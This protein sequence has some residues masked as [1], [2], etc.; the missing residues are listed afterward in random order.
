MKVK[1][2]L[3][4][5]VLACSTLAPAQE[6]NPNPNGIFTAGLSGNV[7][8]V[9]PNSPRLALPALGAQ[10]GV[11]GDGNQFSSHGGNER[12]IGR[13]Q[14]GAF[15]AW[16]NDGVRRTALSSLQIHGGAGIF[17]FEDDGERTKTYYML[18]GNADY[19]SL[20]TQSPDTDQ[21]SFISMVG[22]ELGQKITTRKAVVFVGGN[23]GVGYI[24]AQNG[25][26]PGLDS[27]KKPVM[28]K[29]TYSRTTLAL[30]SSLTAR[31]GDENKKGTVL[32][33]GSTTK[34]LGEGS[35]SNVSL[36][37]NISPHIKVGGGMRQ[38]HLRGN[39]T[40][41]PIDMSGPFGRVTL[42]FQ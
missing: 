35:R 34:L 7:V 29:N 9:S 19:D 39:G 8:S 15:G 14:G 33:E 10:V 36:D 23:S 16:R 13:V 40:N 17:D 5:T 38:L 2:L 22:G 11:I 26:V 1:G 24:N 32:I 4:L 20:G 28:N 18:I 30:G 3:A 42:G 41:G 25:R 12:V 6:G 37:V 31:I 27:S 21:R